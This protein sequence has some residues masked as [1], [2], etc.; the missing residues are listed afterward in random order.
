MKLASAGPETPETRA[1]PSAGKLGLSVEPLPVE[2][3]ERLKTGGRGVRV[4]EVTEDGPA[5]SKI[6]AGSDVVLEVLY[7][8]PRRAVRNVGDLQAAVASLKTGDYISLLVQSVDP[9]LGQ[10]VVNIRVGE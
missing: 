1:N 4:T 8:A 10:R 6:A 2:L 9:R 3:A 7:P 5:A